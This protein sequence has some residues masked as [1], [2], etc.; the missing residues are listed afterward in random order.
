[1]VSNWVMT[2]YGMEI[3]QFGFQSLDF[4]PRDAEG[5]LVLPRQ[6]V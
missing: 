3:V 5:A 4:E 1:M 2:N 6:H